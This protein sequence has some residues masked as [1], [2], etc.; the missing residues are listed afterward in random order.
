M[1]LRYAERVA[2]VEG[3]L[4]RNGAYRAG[5]VAIRCCFV[6]RL[7]SHLSVGRG[8]EAVDSVGADGI[9]AQLFI[10]FVGLFAEEEVEELRG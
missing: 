9:T 7:S 2:A 3:A 10:Y 1:P 4:T 8:L 5:S 6:S